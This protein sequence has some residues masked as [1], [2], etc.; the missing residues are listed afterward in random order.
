MNAK[1][2]GYILRRRFNE[3]V[4]G[5]RTAGDLIEF[6]YDLVS[7]RRTEGANGQTDKGREKRRRA[8]AGES[9]AVGVVTAWMS[10]K[11]A[12]QFG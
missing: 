1:R 5:A 2:R 11:S 8:V 4:R 3:G 9:V 10:A 12:T 7:N 6:L